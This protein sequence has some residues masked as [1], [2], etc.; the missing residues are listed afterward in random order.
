MIDVADA[1]AIGEANPVADP[2]ETIGHRD[3]A[4]GACGVPGDVVDQPNFGSPFERVGLKFSGGGRGGRH[5]D[6]I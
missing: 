6:K 1:L 5:E 4:L 3:L 2:C